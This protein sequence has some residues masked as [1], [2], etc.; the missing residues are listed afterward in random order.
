M[1]IADD[2][3]FFPPGL[4]S[5]H[6]SPALPILRIEKYRNG[7]K[8][9]RYGLKEVI[10]LTTNVDAFESGQ[11]L[12]RGVT[13]NGNGTVEPPKVWSGVGRPQ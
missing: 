2:D 9:A 6:E 1:T 11:E 13:A 7:A 10:C 12:L 5:T 4:I 3:Q 8:I